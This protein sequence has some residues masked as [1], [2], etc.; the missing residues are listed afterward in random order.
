MEGRQLAAIGF[1]ELLIGCSWPD[2]WPLGAAVSG[3]LL[4]LCVPGAVRRVPDPELQAF[5]T[6]LR[7]HGLELLGIPAFID[8]YIIE[9]PEG[10]LPGRRGLRRAALPDRLDRLRLPLRAADVSQPSS[11]GAFIL[12]PSSCRSLPTDYGAGDRVARLSCWAA[13]RRAAADHLIYGWLFFSLVIGLLITAGLPFR[14]DI[15]PPPPRRQT[16]IATDFRA[17]GS[18]CR[19]G[20]GGPGGIQSDRVCR[21]D[22]RRASRVAGQHRCRFGLRDCHRDTG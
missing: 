5:T 11:R 1:V 18:L 13:P 22:K 10:H 7:P 15:A 20:A 21:P 19:I 6:R 14:Q 17:P 16:E 3:P 8:G 2:R 4:Y 12:I 9:I